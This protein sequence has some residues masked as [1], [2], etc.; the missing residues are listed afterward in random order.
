MHVALGDFVLF[1]HIVVAVIAF[2]VAGVLLVSMSAMARA[3]E[4]S[5]VRSWAAVSHRAEPM[6]PILVLFLIALGAWL[7]HLSG[8]RISWSDGWVDVAVVGL[9]L[10]EAYGG[11]VLAPAGKKL[12]ET[13]EAAPDG[14]VPPAIRSKILNRAVWAGA[15]GNTALALGILFDMPTKPS[16]P[17]AIIIVA[18]AGV[19]GIALGLWMCDAAA[20]RAGI[21]APAPASPA[22]APPVEA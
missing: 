13:V 11:I 19:I 9:V 6:F 16:G 15:Y 21:S 1:L 2:G 8:G 22:A 7:I 12:H 10:M 5:V 14:V 20:A 3:T 17:L 18:A 4:M